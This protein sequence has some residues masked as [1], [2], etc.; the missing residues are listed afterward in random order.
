M[1]ILGFEQKKEFHGI[2]VLRSKEK[3][4]TK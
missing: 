3:I 4:K 1:K 2:L